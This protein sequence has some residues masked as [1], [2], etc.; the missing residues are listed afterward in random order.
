VEPVPEHDAL[1]SAEAEDTDGEDGED[2][3][4]GDWYPGISTRH[5]KR[6]RQQKRTFPHYNP[7][8]ESEGP[9]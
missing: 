9:A 8:P 3:E 6:T 1:Q 5:A 2:G 4:D 7:T